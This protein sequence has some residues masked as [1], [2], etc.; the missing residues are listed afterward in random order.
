VA[1][2]RLDTDLEIVLPVYVIGDSHALPYRNLAFRER[3]TG[4]WVTTRAKY[5]SGLA[6]HE[7]FKTDTQ[8]F[9]PELIAVLEYEG[10]VRDGQA[11]HVSREEI[12]F[13]IAKASGAP[14]IPPIVLFTLG[15]ID[16]RAFLMGLLRDKYD[17]VPPFETSIPVSDKPL[18][19]WDAIDELLAQRIGPFVAGLRRLRE[20]GFNRLYVQNVVPPTRNEA[21]IKE[22][23]GYECPVAIRTKLVMAFNKRLVEECEPIS[24]TVI[25]NWAEWTKGGYLRSDLELDGVH[26]PPWTAVRHL[27][28]VLDHAINCQWFAANHVRYELYYRLACEA[29]LFPATAGA[30]RDYKAG[31]SL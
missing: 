27:E 2:S 17:F 18:V 6:A 12:D 13:A 26:L 11:T 7:F 3:W 22:L 28:L 21:R 29:D 31:A 30:D 20:S 4:R 10:L 24:A 14:V 15:D 16:I 25:D 1:K 9:H 23:H 19:P 8:E 5:V